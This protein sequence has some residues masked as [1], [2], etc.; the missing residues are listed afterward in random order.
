M[1]IEV[2]KSWFLMCNAHLT[3][4]RT[5]AMMALASDPTIPEAV[6]DY[7]SAVEQAFLNHQ[8]NL[9]SESCRNTWDQF[10]KDPS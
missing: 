6:I 7:V 10:R 9:R 8:A 3:E 1:S 2:D 5:K 4:L